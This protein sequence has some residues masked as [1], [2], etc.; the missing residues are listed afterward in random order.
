MTPE[1]RGALDTVTLLDILIALGG[2][3]AIVGVITGWVKTVRPLIKAVGD[4][5]R[6]WNGLPARPGRAAEPGFPERM[7]AVE[8][9]LESISFHVQPNHGGSAHDQMREEIAGRLDELLHE[10]AEFRAA[11]R[12]DLAH[13]HPDYDPPD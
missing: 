11:Y 6:D 2:A 8:Q 4:F 7:Q 9:R 1:V 3:L 12:R 5:L 10:L 13:N